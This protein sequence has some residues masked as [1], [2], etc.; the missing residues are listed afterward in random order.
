MIFQCGTCDNGFVGPGPAPSAATAGSTTAK[1]A[2]TAVRTTTSRRCVP[3]DVRE[4]VLRR[5][6]RVDFTEECDDGNNTDSDLCDSTCACEP[7]NPAA[8][9]VRRWCRPA[10]N[11]SSGRNLGVACVNNGDCAIGTCNVSLGVCTACRLDTGYTGVAHASGHQRSRDDRAATSLCNS[12]FASGRNLRCLQ[13]RRHRSERR[14]LPLRQRH[15]CQC[16]EPSRSTPTT[17]AG[18]P[19]TAASAR[20]C[21]CLRATRRPAF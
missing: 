16:D 2:M 10:G 20:R 9:D 8:T 17:A 5:R 13:G 11:W 6:R 19:A 14:P 7:G 21:R 3:H 12:P 18:T 15:S 1:S 4:C